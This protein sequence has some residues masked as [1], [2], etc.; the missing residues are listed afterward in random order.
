MSDRGFWSVSKRLRTRRRSFAAATSFF[1]DLSSFVSV[2]RAAR[3]GLRRFA[4]SC[5]FVSARTSRQMFSATWG[6][7]GYF[8]RVCPT[9]FVLLC[10][11]FLWNSCGDVCMTSAELALRYCDTFTFVPLC[12]DAA[13]D[14]R[15][16]LSLRRNRPRCSPLHS[17]NIREKVKR[18]E[19]GLFERNFDVTFPDGIASSILHC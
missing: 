15:C 2:V 17:Q 1:G 10:N 14:S 18:L 5:D 11:L 13:V 8:R 12:N 6:E 3:G 4:R 19:R 9:T 7:K 16:L